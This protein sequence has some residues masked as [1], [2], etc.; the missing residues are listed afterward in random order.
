MT[1]LLTRL[2][3]DHCKVSMTVNASD[4][5]T[6]ERLAERVGWRCPILSFYGGSG[7]YC[8]NEACQ[9]EAE[10]VRYKGND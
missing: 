5:L 10:R 7:H 2:T 8:K 1:H 4:A 6:A 3:C 9:S